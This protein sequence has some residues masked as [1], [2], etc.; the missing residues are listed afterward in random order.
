MNQLLYDDF[1]RTIPES[2]QNIIDAQISGVITSTIAKSVNVV[3]PSTMTKSEWMIF[4]NQFPPD[5]SDAQFRNRDTMKTP[6][7]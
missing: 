1:N 3:S 4:D 7:K 5:F 2:V 6:A